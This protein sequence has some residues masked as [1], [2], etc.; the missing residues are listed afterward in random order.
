MTQQDLLTRHNVYLDATY[1]GNALGQNHTIKGGYALNRMGNDVLTNY[2]QGR[3]N[4]NWGEGFTRGSIVGRA[5]SLRLL[6]VAGRRP[7]ELAR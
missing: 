2:T 6:H 3:F 1:F 7:A 4:I 5:R